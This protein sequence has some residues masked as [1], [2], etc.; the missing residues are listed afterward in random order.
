VGRGTSSITEVASIINAAR[1]ISGSFIGS[2]FREHLEHSGGIVT[3]IKFDMTPEE[4]HVGIASLSPETRRQFGAD[5]VA[6]DPAW[7]PFVEGI[8]LDAPGRGT[9]YRCGACGFETRPHQDLRDCAAEFDAHDCDA[10]RR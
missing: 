2:N 10:A 1:A 4:F 6:S 9:V 3:T 5:L 8:D 7:V